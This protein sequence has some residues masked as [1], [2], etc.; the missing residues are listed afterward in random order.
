V[1]RVRRYLTAEGLIDEASE[2]RLVEELRAEVDAAFA[3]AQASPAPGS[4]A[5]FDHVY[6]RPPGRLEAQRRAAAE[7]AG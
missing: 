3:E 5:I 7:E 1:Q 6:V 2:Q 4:E